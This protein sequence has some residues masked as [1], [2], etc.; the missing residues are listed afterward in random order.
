MR[1]ALGILTPSVV[2][3]AV[4]R[5]REKKKNEKKIGEKQDNCRVTRER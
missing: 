3:R 2:C 5:G 1:G 4:R